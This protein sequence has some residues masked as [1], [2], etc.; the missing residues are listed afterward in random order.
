VWDFSRGI[1]TIICVSFNHI[2]LLSSTS[3]HY[4]YQIWHSHFS[5]CCHYWP[6]VNIF[7]SPILHNSKICHLWC[8]LSQR[9]ELSQQTPHWSILPLAIEL[10]GYLHKHAYV[11]LHYCANAI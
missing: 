2:Q 10:L 7:T 4:V 6:N 8:S 9:K 1:K 3:W 5:W 11:F